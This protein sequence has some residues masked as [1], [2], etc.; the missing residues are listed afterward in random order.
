MAVCG[1]FCPAKPFVGLNIRG[2]LHMLA[3]GQGNTPLLSSHGRGEAL[4]ESWWCTEQMFM[5]PGA[6][7]PDQIIDDGVDST[8][9][10]HNGKELEATFT[11]AQQHHQPR[12]HVR[13]SDHQGLP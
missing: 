5:W 6:D 9:I 8:M 7:G 10:V 4:A 12:V 2:S 3:H 13:P 1:E 11:K